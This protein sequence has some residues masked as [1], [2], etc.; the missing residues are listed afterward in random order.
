VASGHQ[1]LS[2][3][4]LCTCAHHENLS[5]KII[6]RRNTLSGKFVTERFPALEKRQ[7]L[8]HPCAIDGARTHNS[9]NGQE[10]ERE[11][12]KHGYRPHYFSMLGVQI[13]KLFKKLQALAPQDEDARLLTTIPGVGY[14][15]LRVK[16]EVGEISRFT[17][18]E[19]LCS[20][21]GLSVS[22]SGAHMRHGSITKEDSRWQVC[23]HPSGLTRSRGI[24]HITRFSIHAKAVWMR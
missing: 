11:S 20:Y 13:G 18:G 9:A 15:S 12:W 21:A 4:I 17:D 22:N 16:S 8:S 10:K 23:A 19:K 2:H 5:G 1:N 24:Q 14:H 7:V 3:D 6:T